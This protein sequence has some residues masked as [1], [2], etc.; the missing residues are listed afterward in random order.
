MTTDQKL[1]FVEQA[2]ITNDIKS[3]HTDLESAK[4]IYDEIVSQIN[5]EKSKFVGSEKL[6]KSI[7]MQE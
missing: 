4:Q 1:R 5:E 6:K 3:K 7:K 2:K